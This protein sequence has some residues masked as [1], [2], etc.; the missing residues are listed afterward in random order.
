M[1]LEE[2][3]KQAGLRLAL[4][5]VE[6]TSTRRGSSS[7]SWTVYSRWPLTDEQLSHLVPHGQEFRVLGSENQG[8]VFIYHC[9]EQT[10]SSD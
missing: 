4:V 6:S 7:S 10:D 8:L 1:T 9:W 3:E 2:F 5:H